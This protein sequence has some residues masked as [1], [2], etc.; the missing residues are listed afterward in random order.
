MASTTSMNATLSHSIF[1][2]RCSE[3]KP[4]IN[5]LRFIHYTY[6]QTHNFIV[7]TKQS[8]IRDL[9]YSTHKDTC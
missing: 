2:L 8:R 6:N 7:V 5:S 1:A 9:N 3:S 4:Q